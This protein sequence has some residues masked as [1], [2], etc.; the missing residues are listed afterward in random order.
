M[1]GWPDAH[2]GKAFKPYK[3]RSHELSVLDRC[4]LSGCRFVV[5]PQVQAAVLEE[6]HE[7]HPGASRM[8]ALAYSYIWWSKMDTES[9]PFP[10]TAPVHPWQWPCQLWSRLHLD[11]AEPFMGNMFLI[12]VDSHSKWLDAHIMSSITSTKTI[13]VLRSV[14]AIHGLPQKV[15]TVNVP[16]FMNQ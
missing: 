2:L 8:K 16:S 10:P 12:I 1:I 9:K 14:F 11:F 13:K 5:P 7:T 3:S 4:V 6:L 15:V